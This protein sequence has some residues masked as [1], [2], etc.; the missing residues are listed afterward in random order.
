MN[1][2]EK[3]QYK[4]D[5]IRKT[6]EQ[7]HTTLSAIADQLMGE[8]CKLNVLKYL[9]DTSVFA[10][11]REGKIYHYRCLGA[12]EEPQVTLPI[13]KPKL[14]E[15][16]AQELNMSKDEVSDE[17]MFDILWRYLNTHKGEISIE[18]RFDVF[19]NQFFQYGIDILY[20]DYKGEDKEFAEI[21]AQTLE[22]EKLIEAQV[23]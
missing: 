16:N 19:N 12:N 14:Q 20:P 15:F 1:R 22:A 7:G 6:I 5:L 2:E 9:S 13:E 18:E 10:R 8:M 17:K 3:K 21:K 23:I 11:A 4:I